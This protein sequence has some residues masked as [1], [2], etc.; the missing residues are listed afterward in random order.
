MVCNSPKFILAKQSPLLQPL[1]PPNVLL[2]MKK[3]F[4]IL[5]IFSN[6]AFVLHLLRRDFDDVKKDVGKLDFV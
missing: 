4:D 3:F 5:L 2:I 6:F 1:S